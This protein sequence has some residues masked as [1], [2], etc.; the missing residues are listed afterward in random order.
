MAPPSGPAGPVKR[1]IPCLDVAGG[2][3]V[4]G[5]R[6]E[7]LRDAGDP[8]ELAT[9]YDAE[10]ADELVLL[11]ITATSED[12]A[13]MVAVAREVVRAIGIPLTVGGGVRS[14]D[15]AARLYDAGVAKVSLNSAAVA[16]PE[17]I[18]EIAERFGSQ[19]VVLA[20]DAGP[21]TDGRW[22]VLTRGGA[23]GTGLDVI[24]WARQAAQLGA[25]EILPTSKA[26][27]GTAE[28]YDLALTA[29][30]AEATGLPVIASGGAGSLEHLHEAL[31]RGQAAAVLAASIFHDRRY[32][33]AEAKAYLAGRGIPVHLPGAP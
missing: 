27:D 9:R 10:G 4:K 15:D 33:I 30:I 16:R 29:A 21:G 28:G 31:T 6:F 20:I 23:V 17:L 26:A 5:V 3:V 14:L 1:I 24:E 22:E 8:V 2:R 18:R 25:G 19:R 32:T 7:N 11:D 12:R 13:T